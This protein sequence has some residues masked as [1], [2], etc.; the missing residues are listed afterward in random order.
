ME[1]HTAATTFI[2]FLPL[3]VMSIFFGVTANLLAKEKERNVMTWTILGI[4]PMVNFV[5]IW[6]FAGAANLKLERKMDELITKLDA[7]RNQNLH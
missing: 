5:C 4:I 3:I 1:N 7:A 2:S 6:Y